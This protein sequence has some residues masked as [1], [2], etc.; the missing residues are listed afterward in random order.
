MAASTP[1]IP[2]P[3]LRAASPTL[4]ARRSPR[5]ILIGVLCACLGGLGCALA[6]QQTT[7]AHQVVVA[8]RSLAR[9]ELIDAGDLTTTSIGAAPGVSTVSA[10]RLDELI[11][12]TALVDLPAGALVATESI[13]EPRLATGFSVIGLHL[14]AGRVPGGLVS[15]S[16]VV[17]ASAPAL[18]D[19]ADTAPERRQA[20]GTV[21]GPPVQSSDGS[22]SLDV[23]VSADAALSLAELAAAGRIIVI[24]TG[25]A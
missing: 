10:E 2:A 22:W 24:Q 18:G 20:P 14:A 16:D 21:V 13:G 25:G 19:T 5:L 17:L 11:G 8:A 9:G 23:R 12:S 6:W 4:R 7:H 15:G 1:R 3:L